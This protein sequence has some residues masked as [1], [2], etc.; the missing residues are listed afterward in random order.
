MEIVTRRLWMHP[1]LI[2]LFK[3]LVYKTWGMGKQN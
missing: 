2:I 1:K 3:K